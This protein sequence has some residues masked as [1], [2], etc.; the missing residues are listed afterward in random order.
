MINKVINGDSMKKNFSFQFTYQ[1]IILVLPLIISPYLTRVLGGEALGIYT[2]TYSIA[3]YFVVCANLGISKHGQRIVAE[4]K[5]DVDNLRKTVW[6]LILFHMIV[7]LIVLFLYVIY[8]L[9]FCKKY[10]NIA[11][12]QT[13]FV[14]ST[15]LDY[16]WFF[17]GIEKFKNVVIRNAIV[18]F[19]EFILIFFLVK[20]TDDLMIYTLIMSLS[21]CLGHIAVL[22]QIIKIIPPIKVKKED[23]KEHIKPMCI[24]FIASIA[25]TL[26]TVFDKTLLGLL[27]NIEDVAI[28]EYSNKIITIPRSFIVIISTVLFPKACKM[29]AEGDFG[30][31]EKD[32]ENSLMI[33]Y[34]I[35]FA[36]IWG[37]MGISN[38]FAEIYYG[39]EFMA[40]GNVMIAMSPLILII[41]LGEVLRSQY[42]Y[43]LKKDKIMVKIL[44]MNALINLVISVLL[45][46]K[47]GVYGAVIGTIMAELFGLI[48]QLIL[49]K[50]YIKVSK[51][52]KVGVPFFIIGF[53][54]F[55]CIKLLNLILKENVYSLL[56][57]I[58]IGG[59]IYVI[60]SVI[61]SYK[62]NEYIK[63][64]CN[65]LLKNNRK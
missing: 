19:L 25:A 35:G 62:N 27:S 5:S 52:F 57:Q 23:F 9:F 18:K 30:E 58:M 28:Y 7:S 61:Y 16:T 10:F 20:T 56:I 41:G 15:I 55:V 29:I 51:F 53:I 31:V 1:I 59:F 47:I 8:I 21:V 2:F 14:F 49:C 44:F 42:I 48:F 4:R 50:K 13:I 3:Y 22:P 26:Y 65:K 37:L 33:N 39:I 36:S 34:F 11:M 60:L 6:S 12:I 43:P 45:I 63:N 32:L 54:M 46:P 17:Q 38:L 64:I 24:L 40:C